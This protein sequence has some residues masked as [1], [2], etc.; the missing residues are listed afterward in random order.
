MYLC[1]YVYTHTYAQL[2][3]M[4]WGKMRTKITYCLEYTI[5]LSLALIVSFIHMDVVE[6]ELLIQAV[7]LYFLKIYN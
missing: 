4:R 5:C 7:F 2:E 1:M 6:S 3:C